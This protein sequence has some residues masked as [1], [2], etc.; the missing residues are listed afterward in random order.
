MPFG[1]QI[2]ISVTTEEYIWKHNVKSLYGTLHNFKI[3][4]TE[5]YIQNI[6]EEEEARVIIK[7]T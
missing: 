3:L 1:K 2:N 4:M 7:A 5:K 6:K